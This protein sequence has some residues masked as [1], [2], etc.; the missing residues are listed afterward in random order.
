MREKFLV[1]ACTLCVIVV[2]LRTAAAQIKS[3]LTPFPAEKV[4]T[5]P[6]NCE[7]NIAILDAA[8][9][10]AGND[11]LVIVIARL[12]RNERSELS[13]RRLHNVKTY[14]EQFAG[15][16]TQTIITAEGDR[17]N[18]YGLVELYV[19]GQHFYTLKVRSNSDLI[20]GQCSYDVENPCKLKRESK[21]YPCLDDN[22]RLR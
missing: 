14:L 22:A 17:V 7:F 20:V 13:R 21:L 15:R 11:G 8:H 16:R 4:A 3:E 18:G 5:E 1:F 19:K 10:Q 9:S 2:C 12:G 6:T